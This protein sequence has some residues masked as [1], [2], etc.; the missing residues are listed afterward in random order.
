MRV[1]KRS[2]TGLFASESLFWHLLRGGVAAVLLRWAIEHQAQP[3]L[4][5][6]AAAGA[7]VAF[8]GCPICWTVG[9]IET[10]VHRILA[11]RLHR[12]GIGGRAS[13]NVAGDRGNGGN[14][15]ER[16]DE[17]QRVSGPHPE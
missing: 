15:H 16:C 2:A 12:I 17:A 5:L 4:S 6:L 8:R 3:T 1:F 7:L 13:R 9:L 10:I 11:K 14:Q